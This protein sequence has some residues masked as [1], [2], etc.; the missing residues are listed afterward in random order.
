MITVPEFVRVTNPAA[1]QTFADQT[2]EVARELEAIP[3]LNG[4]MCEIP[5][6]VAAGAFIFNH[7]L[8]RVPRGW[9]VAYV[10][11]P[12]GTNTDWSLYHRSGDQWTNASLALYATGGFDL[13]RVWVF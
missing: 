12:S 11:L 2:R 3:F 10:A 5:A 9:L 6:R 4:V 8:R 1:L 13:L 7:G